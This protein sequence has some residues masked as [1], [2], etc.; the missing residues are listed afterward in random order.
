MIRNNNI[1]IPCG[2]LKE[3][4]TCFYYYFIQTGPPRESEPSREGMTRPAHESND[5]VD[6]IFHSHSS[7]I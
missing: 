7:P 1:Y 6:P 5:S 4:Q 2:A 3:V